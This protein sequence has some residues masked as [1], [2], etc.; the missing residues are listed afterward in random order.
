[1]PSVEAKIT[2]KGQ[3]TLPARLRDRLNV[4][5]GDH[6]VFVEEPDGRIVVT[7]RTGSL[8][9]MRGMLK[10][11]IKISK[12][13]DIES[14]IDEARSRALPLGLRKRRPRR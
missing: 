6:I 12:P 1:M 8:A 4:G 9:D 7:A 13:A 5:P 10:G 2:S 11:K 3:V 14:W